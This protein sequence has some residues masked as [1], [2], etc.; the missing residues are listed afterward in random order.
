MIYPFFN[1]IKF[2]LTK[3]K[4]IMKI[5]VSLITNNKIKKFMKARKIQENFRIILIIK[6]INSK[7]K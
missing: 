1:I 2:K 4:K 6:Y 3:I 7:Y 5:K